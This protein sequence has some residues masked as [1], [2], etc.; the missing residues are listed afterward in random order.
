MELSFWQKRLSRRRLLGGATGLAI[1]GA[2]GG[3]LLPHRGLVRTSSAQNP[4]VLAE[5]IRHYASEFASGDLQGLAWSSSSGQTVMRAASSSGGIYTSPIAQTSFPATHI[6][7]HWL[8]DAPAYDQI[9]FEL[10]TSSDGWTWSPWRTLYIEAEPN[11]NPR[12]ER[13]AS[14]ISAAGTTHVQY[15]AFFPQNTPDATALRNVTVTVLAAAPP[16]E[17][18][19]ALR[20][21]TTP[22]PKST[23]SA[24][25]S[26]KDAGSLDPP[27]AQNVLVSRETWGAPENYRYDSRGYEVW[28]RMYLPTKKLIVHHT[29]TA[30]NNPSNPLYPYPGYSA[31]DAVQEV[32]AIY[33]YHAITLGWGDIGYNALIDR[34]GRIFEGRRGRDSGPHGTREII[35][36][37]VVAGHALNCN[38]GTS[39]V[40]LIGNYDVNQIGPNEQTMLSTLV[41]FLSW[42]CRRF[43]IWPNAASDFLQVNWVWRQGVQDI[44][45]HRDLNQTACPGQYLYAYLPN[46]RQSVASRVA[47]LA[48]VKPSAQI[49][50]LPSQ[51]NIDAHSVTFNWKSPDS[52]AAEFSYYL[53]GWIPNLDTDEDYYI[54]GFTNDKRPDWSSFSGAT[55]AT[56]NV[57]QAARYTFHVRARDS[58]SDG[59]YEANWTFVAGSGPAPAARAIGVPGVIKN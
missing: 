51:A 22:T 11:E 58:K 57:P 45:G 25:S 53:E 21:T 52:S 49:T 19:Q 59:A 5:D 9:R 32:R 46:I 8:A 56:L 38:E 48:I 12:R 41:E 14:L 17:S 4:F 24:P 15:R 7:L 31:D 54:S 28:S 13:F 26:T 33:Y 3:L 43:Y 44:S 30:E 40:S 36:P 35:S 50:S 2:G 47:A 29:A 18:F 20:A 37:N 10:R 39:G 16:D 55:S 1:A 34:F 23:S 27:F 6:G 42:S